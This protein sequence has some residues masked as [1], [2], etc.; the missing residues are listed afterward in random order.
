MTEQIISDRLYP[1]LSIPGP[2]FIYSLTQ[3]SL[4]LPIRMSVMMQVALDEVI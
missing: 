2:F 4:R 1:S 3:V